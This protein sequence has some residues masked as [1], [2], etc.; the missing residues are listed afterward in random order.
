[1]QSLKQ[2]LHHNDDEL[3]ETLRLLESIKE[4]RMPNQSQN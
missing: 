1:M 3:P 4:F 2:S